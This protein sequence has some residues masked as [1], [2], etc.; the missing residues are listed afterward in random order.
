MGGPPLG[1]PGHPNPDDLRE[2]AVHQES[3]R[4]AHPLPAQD[5]N[6]STPSIH[7]PGGGGTADPGTRKTPGQPV[8][9][10]LV[11]HRR[12]VLS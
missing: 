6:L 11:H 1:W 3:Q 8:Y 4:K 7:P 9:V 12:N 5:R 10:S 2:Q